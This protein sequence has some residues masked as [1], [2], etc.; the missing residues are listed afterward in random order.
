MKKLNKY[1]CIHA[2]IADLDKLNKIAEHYYQGNKS[3]A[4]R[5]LIEDKY[6]Q[7]EIREA[8]YQDKKRE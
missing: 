3:Y 6:R 8:Y 2:R 7:L 4:L 1:L 5:A